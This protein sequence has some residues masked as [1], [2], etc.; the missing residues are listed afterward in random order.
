MIYG[1]FD[2][3]CEDFL[4]LTPFLELAQELCMNEAYKAG[5]TM[6]AALGLAS[7][8]SLKRCWPVI[9]ER[10][11]EIIIVEYPMTI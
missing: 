7:S 5:Y 4:F 3:A 6:F 9:N 8:L 10:M 2:K 11:N 1:V